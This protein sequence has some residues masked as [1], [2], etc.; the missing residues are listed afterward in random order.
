MYNNNNLTN[1]MVET[2]VSPNELLQKIAENCC[3]VAKNPPLPPSTLDCTA[4]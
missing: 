2:K 1:I 4:P 3:I